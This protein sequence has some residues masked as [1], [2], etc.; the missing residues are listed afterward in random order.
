MLPTAQKDYTWDAHV[1]YYHQMYLE[2]D[3]LLK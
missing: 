2:Q 1:Y 3:T